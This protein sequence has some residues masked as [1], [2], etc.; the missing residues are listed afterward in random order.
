MAVK[1][2][3][4]IPFAFVDLNSLADNGSSAPVLPVKAPAGKVFIE[5]PGR[6]A[7][8]VSGIRLVRGASPIFEFSEED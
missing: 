6:S 1:V 4:S 3:G 7:S 5:A 2:S 8:E